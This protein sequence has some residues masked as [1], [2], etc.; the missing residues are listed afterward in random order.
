LTDLQ[1]KTKQKKILKSLLTDQGAQNRRK[2]EVFLLIKS[3]NHLE[4]III[5]PA[6]PPDGARNSRGV[7]KI[8]KH[9]I[10]MKSQKVVGS[11]LKSFFYLYLF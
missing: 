9:W 4:A 1:N 8:E 6:L 11:T 5:V 3:H 10:F 7:K 2:L